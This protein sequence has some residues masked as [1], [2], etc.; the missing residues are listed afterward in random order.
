ML[1]ARLR[2]VARP[3]FL[4]VAAAVLVTAVAPAVASWTVPGTGSGVAQ[5]SPDFH[6]PSVNSATI[7]PV[8]MTA[9]GGGVRAGGQFVVYAKLTD[10]GGT[11]VASARSNVS[12]LAAGATSVVL[13]P[14][15]SSCTIG[16]TTYTWSS[17]PRHGGCRP[18]AGDEVVHGLGHRQRLEHRLADVVLGRR[19]QH[20]PHRLGGRHRRVGDVGRRV[21]PPG[22]HLR[23]V[24]QRH[25]RRLAGE[26]HRHRHRRRQHPERRRDRPRV[27]GLHVELHD[28][29]HDLRVQERRHDRRVARRAGSLLVPRHGDRQG[30]RNRRVQR[31]RRPSTTPPP[32]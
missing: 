7:A 29:R 4:V 28:R 5:A 24:R 12:A 3:R 17:A 23:G 30:R 11:G 14:C 2:G 26:R 19:R 21:R 13:S 15:V 20:Q 31:R 18:H 6:A 22:R 27:A 8:G 25:R 1:P 16:A 10:P 32:R 9:A